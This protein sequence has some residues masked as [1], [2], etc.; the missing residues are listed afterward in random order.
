MNN[1]FGSV[2]NPGG[3]ASIKEAVEK[4]AGQGSETIGVLKDSASQISQ[5][6]KDQFARVVDFIQA[7]PMAGIGIALGLGYFSRTIFRLGMLA[8]G[9]YVLMH[10]LPKNRG[11]LDQP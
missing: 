11:G 5:E 8:A 2:S 9:G 3:T 6:V 4:I 1:E 10:F 7:R